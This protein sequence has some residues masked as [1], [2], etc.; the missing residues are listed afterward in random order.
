MTLASG[1]E[2][3]KVQVNDE[4]VPRLYVDA[5]VRLEGICFSQHNTSRQFLNPLLLVPHGVKIVVQKPP[6]SDPFALAV[7]P[8]ASLLEFDRR[9]NFGH[10]VHLRG[11]VTHARPGE[12][13]WLRDG[14]R[15]LR[16]F[17]T[18]GEALLA[19]DEV[20]VVGFPVGGQ[21]TP[22]LE[23]AVYRKTARASAA[24]RHHPDDDARGVET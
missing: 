16:V 12:A 14:D 1:S 8:V 24:G 22:V 10:R 19:G 20:D 3:L 7:Q 9:A 11:L 4:L 5:E 2:R 21:Y 18:E 23:D 15:G 17:S 13:L 6:G